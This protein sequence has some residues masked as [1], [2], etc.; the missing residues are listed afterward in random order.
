MRCG[1]CAG[2]LCGLIQV[3]GRRTLGGV[4]GLGGGNMWPSVRVMRPLRVCGHESV[5]GTTVTPPCARGPLEAARRRSWRARRTILPWM[6]AS[7]RSRE[8][9]FARIFHGSHAACPCGK[10]RS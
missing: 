3:S 6:L 7:A 4:G 1:V 8:R 5:L 2:G 10:R 9:S